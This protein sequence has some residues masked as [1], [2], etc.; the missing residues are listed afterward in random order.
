M[1]ELIADYCRSVF[2]E[3]VAFLMALLIVYGL[4]VVHIKDRHCERI[5]LLALNRKVQLVLEIKV[6]MSV[7]HTG[8]RI[9]IG[10]DFG[11]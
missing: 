10:A 7:L 6:S 4:E 1:L 9:Y 8:Q 3:S 5:V 2:D 11:H